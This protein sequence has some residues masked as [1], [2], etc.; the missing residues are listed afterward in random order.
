MRAEL[1][2]I[3]REFIEP[4]LLVGRFGSFQAAA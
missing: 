2:D 3:E 4:F 1:T